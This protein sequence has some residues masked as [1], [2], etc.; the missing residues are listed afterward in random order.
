M[1]AIVIRVEDTE[2]EEFLKNASESLFGSGNALLR[3][4]ILSYNQS[5]PKEEPKPSKAKPKRKKKP[6]VAAS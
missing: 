3:A 6:A 2:R 4:F 5:F 1:K